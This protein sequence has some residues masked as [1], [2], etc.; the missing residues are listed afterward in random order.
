MATFG[1]LRRLG[2]VGGA[3]A[4]ALTFLTTNWQV[5]VSVIAAIG[6]G[7]VD[8]LRAL[9][10]NAAVI[11]GAGS[12]LAVLWTI[13]AVTVLLDRRRPRSVKTQVDYRY[14]LTFEGLQPRYT[15]PDLPVPEAGS[16]NFGLVVRNFTPSP[17]RYE[18]ENIDIRLGTR[19]IP[20]IQAGS[21]Y[22]FMARG[23]GRMSTIKGFT[24]E[25][26]K[27]FY[28]NADSPTKGSVEVS[29]L[30]GPPEGP[31]ERRLKLFMEIYVAIV[32]HGKSLGWSDS[33]VVE[34]DEP[35]S[36]H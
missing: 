3:I 20:R 23:A 22:G 7:A 26:L 36:P 6:A 16:L 17:I 30:Y 21:M 32:Q 15:E 25:Q 29:Y 9:I 31:P 14:G 24:K 13:V 5:V 10:L 18:I 11:A 4:N 2:P 19:A 1:R 8:W 33:I 27:E 28:D 12:F 34:R 35:L